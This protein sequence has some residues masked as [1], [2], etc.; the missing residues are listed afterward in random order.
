MRRCIDKKHALLIYGEKKPEFDIEGIDS[1]S[2]YKKSI[3]YLQRIA[4]RIELVDVLFITGDQST[5]LIKQVFYP[6]IVVI[7][8]AVDTDNIY[9][10]KCDSPLLAC[11][12]V[13]SNETIFRCDCDNKH[14][15]FYFKDKCDDCNHDNCRNVNMCSGAS[16][17][18]GFNPKTEE[19]KWVSPPPG[20]AYQTFGFGTT[21]ATKWNGVSY[22]Y[23]DGSNSIVNY[24]KHCYVGNNMKATFCQ[25]CGQ[26]M[27]DKTIT[28]RLHISEPPNYR[29]REPL[30]SEDEMKKIF[31]FPHLKNITKYKVCAGCEG[32]KCNRWNKIYTCR[33]YNFIEIEPDHVCDDWH[34]DD[35][36]CNKC[37]IYFEERRCPNCKGKGVKR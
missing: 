29:K 7:D 13:E 25:N 17:Y 12:F 22:H 1:I 9:C 3:D 8:H 5:S 24:C 30:F 18:S 14:Y 32:F 23:D 28:D 2:T 34:S 26:P 37:L 15:N 11:L 4:C 10:I 20:M 36:Y 31:K 16:R 21:S 33:T 19:K 35:K 6:S 27:K